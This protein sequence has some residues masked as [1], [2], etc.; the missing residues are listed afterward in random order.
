MLSAIEAA[1]PSALV[2]MVMATTMLLLLPKT[3]NSMMTPRMT[4]IAV[5]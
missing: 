1:I 5:D 4:T 3:M 2:M